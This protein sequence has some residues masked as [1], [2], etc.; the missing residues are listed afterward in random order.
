MYYDGFLISE[1][2]NYNVV[3]RINTFKF[4]IAVGGDCYHS[5]YYRHKQAHDTMFSVAKIGSRD[6]L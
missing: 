1:L 2:V 4:F 3:L 5:R 6:K